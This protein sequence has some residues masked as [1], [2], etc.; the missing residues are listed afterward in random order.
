MTT[1][2]EKITKSKELPIKVFARLGVQAFYEE[3]K[4]YNTPVLP[5]GAKQPKTFEEWLGCYY[6]PEKL[7]VLP[8]GLNWYDAIEA[9]WEFLADDYIDCLNEE[10]QD[11]GTAEDFETNRKA[12]KTKWEV[13]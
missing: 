13:F 1:E 12:L 4:R 8:K 6:S 5:E 3:V 7:G 2:F 11:W 10:A 9:L